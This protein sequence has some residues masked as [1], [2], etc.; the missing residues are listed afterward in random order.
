MI[1]SALS[2]IVHDILRTSLQGHLE[3]V[4]HLSDSLISILL[5]KGEIQDLGIEVRLLEIAGSKLKTPLST[6]LQHT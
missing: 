2:A 3:D 6:E 4:L 5:C 1:D